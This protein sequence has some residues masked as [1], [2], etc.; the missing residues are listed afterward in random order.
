V[1]RR[2]KAVLI[3][4]ICHSIEWREAEAAGVYHGSAK[5]RADGFL[6]FSTAEQLAGAF[7]RYYADANDL[8]LVALEADA[9]G[10][11]LKFEASRDSAPFPHLYGTLPLSAVKWTRPIVD[12]R[13]PVLTDIQKIEP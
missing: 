2:R 12:G 7:A 1:V 4:K 3:F 6:H 10:P 9:L 13:I 11:V 8:V 5:D